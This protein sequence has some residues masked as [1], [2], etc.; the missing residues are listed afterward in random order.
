MKKS[1]MFQSFL[2]SILSAEEVMK[3]AQLVGYHETARKFLIYTLLQYW[4]Q[5]SYSSTFSRSAT[6]SW[7]EKLR[8]SR[9]NTS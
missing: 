4:T 6:L 2:Q 8:A 1:A 7:T 5:G 3:T 9:I